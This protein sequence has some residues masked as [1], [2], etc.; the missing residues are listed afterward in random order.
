LQTSEQR[1]R[2]LVEQQEDV[3]LRKLPDGRLSFVN[4]SF[5][6]TFGTVRERSLGRPFT[7]EFHPAEQVGAPPPLTEHL[8]S[9]R[10]RYDQRVNTLTGWRWFA[11]ED[12]VI[13]S[14]KGHVTEIQSIGRDITEQKE[15]E[16]ALR[17]ARDRAEEGN[18][19]KSMFLATM[20]HEIRTP[21]NGVIGMTGLL[22]DTQLTPEQRSYGTAV[23]ES[24]EALLDIINDILDFSK[25]E[26]GMMAMEETEAPSNEESNTRRSELPTVVPKPFS[27]GSPV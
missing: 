22:L 6:R 19:A 20:S 24:A 21:M 10:A 26:S 23:R 11:W 17:E 2:G 8:A 25:I 27:N 12:Y 5:C 16:G 1:Y 18:R 15:F 3:I 7:P 4:D 14:D 13:R 9:L